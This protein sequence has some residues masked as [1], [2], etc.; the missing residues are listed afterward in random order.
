[1]LIAN[2]HSMMVA[3]TPPDDCSNDIVPVI[4]A[5]SVHIKKKCENNECFSLSRLDAVK[6]VFSAG[7]FLLD[8]SVSLTP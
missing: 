2:K 6:N 7:Y 4:Q 5:L 8:T 3:A 1:M